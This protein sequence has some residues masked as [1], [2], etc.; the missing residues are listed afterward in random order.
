MVDLPSSQALYG[1]EKIGTSSSSAYMG[2][3]TLPQEALPG[4]GTPMDRDFEAITIDHG[5][6]ALCICTHTHARA[7]SHSVHT[8]VELMDKDLAAALFDEAEEEEEG[9]TRGFELL[10][11]DFVL[12]V[13]MYVCVY[14]CMRRVSRI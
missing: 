5:K 2:G 14:V 4:E 12:E 3:L 11:D 7:R 9:K 1:E 6:C 8:C 13:C 10:N